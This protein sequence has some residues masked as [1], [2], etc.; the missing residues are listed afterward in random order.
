MARAMMPAVILA[1]VLAIVAVGYPVLFPSP[2]R[3]IQKRLDELVQAINTQAEGLDAMTKAVK[4]GH[5]FTEDVTVDFGDGPPVHGRETLMALAARLQDR[6]RSLN[7]ALRDIDI[8]VGSDKTTAE[9]ALTVTV[10]SDDSL[11]AREFQV[12]M[13][14]PADRWLIARA[15][16]VRVLQK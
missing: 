16:G 12:E 5:A 10:S 15:T 6:A 8:A 9:V 7:I 11:D 1:V 2:Q 3:Q 14:K 13:V 4:I